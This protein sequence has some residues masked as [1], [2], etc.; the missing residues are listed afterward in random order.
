M[1]NSGFDVGE[2]KTQVQ[3]LKENARFSE[4]RLRQ[5]EQALEKALFNLSRKD[6]ELK[7]TIEEQ[8]TL[9]IELAV[10]NQKLK[11]EVEIN[12]LLKQNAIKKSTV[13]KFQAFMVSLLFL[14]SSLLVGFGIN[15]LTGTPPNST[16]WVLI[17]LAGIVY[18]IAALLTSFLTGG[19]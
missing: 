11:Y 13:T 18:I 12:S 8:N 9:K 4:E 2:L 7:R 6:A 19:E 16:G 3:I 17:V 5:K 1:E 14:V 10:T 15:F